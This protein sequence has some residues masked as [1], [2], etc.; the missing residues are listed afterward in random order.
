MKKIVGKIIIPHCSDDCVYYMLCTTNC[1]KKHR[2]VLYH[3]GVLNHMQSKCMPFILSHRSRMM[4][5]VFDEVIRLIQNGMNFSSIETV[6]GG[7]F[8]DAF[9]LK[10]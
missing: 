1:T 7:N 3:A 2:I 10:Q 4:I 9:I 8:T 5:S 6:L